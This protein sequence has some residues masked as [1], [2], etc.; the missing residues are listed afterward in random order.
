VT[1]LNPTSCLA[2]LAFAWLVAADANGPYYGTCFGRRGLL[3]RDHPDFRP[4]PTLESASGIP[5]RA[6]QARAQAR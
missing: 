2:A 1:P 6:S 5:P 4:V 3:Y